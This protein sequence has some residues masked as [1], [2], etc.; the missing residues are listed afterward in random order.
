M[1]NCKYLHTELQRISGIA[2]QKVNKRSIDGGV[3][4]VQKRSI[5]TGA[6]FAFTAIN[7]IIKGSELIM[8]VKV[9]FL[10]IHIIRLI[11]H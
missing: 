1:D 2:G 4:K 3:K 11:I 6:S 5:L 7:T 9:L 10:F 8:N